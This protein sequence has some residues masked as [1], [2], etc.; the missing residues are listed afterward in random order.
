L[1]RQRK[2]PLYTRHH[3]A[4][5]AARVCATVHLPSNLLQFMKE[6]MSTSQNRERLLKCNLTR[7]LRVAA[8]SMT[9][10]QEHREYCWIHVD[11]RRKADRDPKRYKTECICMLNTNIIDIRRICLLNTAL[12]HFQRYIPG[13]CN[14]P[15]KNCKEDASVVHCGSQ[16]QEHSIIKKTIKTDTGTRCRSCFLTHK[17]TYRY[18]CWIP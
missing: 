13:T 10:I 6:N 18:C 1:L 8:G 3:C 11:G 17:T 9:I 16:I 15:C 14:N 4:C 2:R 7:V 5:Q 12:R